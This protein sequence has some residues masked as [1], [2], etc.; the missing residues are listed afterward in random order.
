MRTAAMADR[1]SGGRPAP[2]GQLFELLGRTFCKVSDDALE[3]HGQGE[4]L[5]RSTRCRVGS[6]SA[7]GSRGWLRAPAACALPVLSKKIVARRAQHVLHRREHR[8]EYL[9][10]R[11]I[12]NLIR[13]SQNVL[14]NTFPWRVDRI[15]STVAARACT[16]SDECSIVVIHPTCQEVAEVVREIVAVVP[17]ERVAFRRVRFG[18]LSEH[19]L[20]DLLRHVRF[21]NAE[22]FLWRAVRCS[23]CDVDRDPVAEAIER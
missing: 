18:E 1:S 3:V 22:D 17:E 4:A 5:A 21:S 23:A 15:V 7:C 9:S 20:H 11:G 2:L 12:E 13:Q 8:A 16:H 19:L 14:G 6:A 10:G